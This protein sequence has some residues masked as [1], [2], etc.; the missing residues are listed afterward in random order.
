MQEALLSNSGVQSC[1]YDRAG[2]G[3]SEPYPGP[4]SIKQEVDALHRALSALRVRENIILVGASYGG[5]MIRAYAS[6]YP[7]NILGT[8]Y[9]D[10]N[11]VY[12]FDRHPAV[13]RET[14]ER[15]GSDG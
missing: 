12:F 9:V 7:D 15:V 11:S 10:S 8:V 4:F 6:K 2:H 13:I 5:F 1:S 3:W 14:G